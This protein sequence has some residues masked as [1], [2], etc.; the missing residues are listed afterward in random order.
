MACIQP[1]KKPV[2]IH[3]ELSLYIKSRVQLT[4]KV[5][6]EFGRTSEL[7]SSQGQEW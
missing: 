4:S 7:V 5:L 1:N 2:E 3:M 6:Q